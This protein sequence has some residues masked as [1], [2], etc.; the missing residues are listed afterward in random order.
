MGVAQARRRMPLAI[1]LMGTL[2][3]APMWPPDSRASTGELGGH[4]A[5]HSGHR[6]QPT[7]RLLPIPDNN[8]GGYAEAVN[9][10]GVVVGSTYRHQAGQPPLRARLWRN[11][12]MHR[13]DVLT[14][15]VPAGA[16]SF[17][18]TAVDINDHGTIAI[19][20]WYRGPQRQRADESLL[21][22]DGEQDQLHGF[23][24][25]SRAT[26]RALSK[27]DRAVGWAQ[28]R[29]FNWPVFW[30]AHEPVKADVPSTAA[31]HFRGSVEAV[32]AAGQM[33]GF[34][35]VHRTYTPW[36]WN[37]NGSGHALQPLTGGRTG[38]AVGIDDR[39]R[40]VGF[41]FH[42]LETVIWR[43]PTSAPV[44][45]A[46]GIW[47]A[48]SDQTLDVVGSGAIV[49]AHADAVPRSLPGPPSGPTRDVEPAD[50][51][52]GVSSLAPDGGTTVVGAVGY[53]NPKPV[54]WT[55]AYHHPRR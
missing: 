55:C 2:V 42:P 3:V 4:A 54:V 5:E 28:S 22:K 40:M 33:A 27:N 14:D 24:D 45:V 16:R 53:N 37:A 25:R 47:P 39:G 21:I 31:G 9:R 11:G 10:H 43:T 32:N 26:I 13:I 8:D 34:V 41:F 6:C 17:G 20:R 38:W 7:T 49:R 30:R 50:V 23:N 1:L 44:V 35:S 52:R 48:H 29:G 51:V 19:D 18:S 36:Y 15:W 46:R 12:Q